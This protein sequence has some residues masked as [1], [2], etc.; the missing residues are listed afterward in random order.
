MLHFVFWFYFNSTKSVDIWEGEVGKES[1]DKNQELN[2]SV[3]VLNSWLLVLKT[4]YLQSP[5]R[6]SSWSE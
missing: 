6:F 5:Q 3:L 2:I 1:R 4:N